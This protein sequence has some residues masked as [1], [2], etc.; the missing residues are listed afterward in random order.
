[1]ISDVYSVIK[2]LVILLIGLA[3]ASMGVKETVDRLRG[4]VEY[5]QQQL[6]NASSDSTS[7][8]VRFQV[9]L[10]SEDPIGNVT[11][12]RSKSG[13]ERSRSVTSQFFVAVVG[14]KL[15][16]IESDDKPSSNGFVGRFEELTEEHRTQLLDD[17]PSE[18]FLSF[19]IVEIRNYG[20]TDG[21]GLF[22]L[23]VGFTLL[24]Y[25]A[26]QLRK[27]LGNV[28]AQKEP[29]ENLADVPIA[30]SDSRDEVPASLHHFSH[31]QPP[32]GVR[33]PQLHKSVPD[34]GDNLLRK[35]T[36]S[37]GPNITFHV[38]GKRPITLQLN[39]EVVIGRS[40]ECE[41]SV[42]EDKQASKKHAS[43]RL[44]SGRLVL[45]DLGSSNGTFLN[46]SKVI[47]IEPIA[48]GD[49]IVVGRSEI[50]VAF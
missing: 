16:L 30:R 18:M 31:S 32:S 5:S 41:V 49:S 29:Q 33:E 4:P 24:A 21:G 42:E 19:R 37:S 35:Q 1:M 50:R 6:I 38:Q 23:V 43:V 39:D 15:L 17:L 2:Q 27:S 44:R 12:I 14:D 7:R 36:K 13:V 10:L 34:A 47:G 46:G 8:L 25:S 40:Q 22:L 9:D 28:K 45:Q 48:D 26:F 11:T 20:W 3:L